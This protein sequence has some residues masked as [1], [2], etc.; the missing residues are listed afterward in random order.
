MQRVTLDFDTHFRQ[1]TATAIKC[2]VVN[3]DDQLSLFELAFE[4]YGAVD[5]VVRILPSTASPIKFCVRAVLMNVR[6]QMRESQKAQ[7]VHV[8]GT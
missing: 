1:R 6:S 4:Q 2:N 3:W 7:E 8:L 5:I